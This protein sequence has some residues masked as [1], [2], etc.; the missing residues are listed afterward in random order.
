MAWGWNMK[1]PKRRKPKMKRT[2]NPNL[3]F[4]PKL[5]KEFQLVVA[6]VV[7]EMDPNATVR[8][9]EWVVGPDGRRDLDVVVE[10]TV[11]GVVRRVQ[12]ECKDYSN[13]GRPIGI[14]LIDA[15]DSKHRDLKMDVSMMCSNGG[16]TDDA[17]RKA[18]RL[19]IGLVGVLRTKD[20]RIRY[21]VLDEIYIRRIELGQKGT[22]G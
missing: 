4:K 8:E 15:L 18:K 6:D 9:G 22:I 21:R 7:R 20:P 10:G 1:K 14:A 13:E 11:A 3:S 19:G 12:I 17:I 5:G 16:F 2:I